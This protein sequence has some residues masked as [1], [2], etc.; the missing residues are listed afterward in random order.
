MIKPE[1][2]VV[3]PFHNEQG[4]ILEFF[5]RIEKVMGKLTKNWE[6]VAVD[7]GSTDKTLDILSELSR[8]DRRVKL[9]ILSR[10][11]GHE[12]AVTAGLD[13]SSGEITVLMDGD[14]Q[15]AP[16]FIPSLLSR[17]NEGFDVVYAKH[18][19]R[20]DGFFK[21]LL[22]RGFYWL[23][24]SVSSFKLPLDA[25]AFSIMRRPAVVAL[26]SFAERNRYVAG[27]RAWIGFR[28]GELIYEKQA[29]FSGKPPQ[30]MGKLFRMGLDALFSF[31]YVPLRLATFMG[32]VVTLGAVVASIDVIYQKYFSH[33]AIVGWSGPMLS[34]LIT[35][36][37]Q[38]IILGIV[39]EYLGRIYDEVRKRPYYI[40][41]DK[42]NLSS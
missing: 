14:L 11:F 24:G 1:F 21:N 5:D 31:S 4:N 33:T 25:G 39:G 32:M 8:K 7:D 17:L 40:V 28:Q 15:D 37:V 42:V 3:V 16:E 9:V 41:K 22:F 20:H 29:R 34:I 26:A 19:I 36:G 12:P 30:T 6:L 38:L 2:S 27:L 13:N 35:G 18:P 10:N 23:M